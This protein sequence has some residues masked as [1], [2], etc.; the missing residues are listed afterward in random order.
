MK[1]AVTEERIPGKEHPQISPSQ[2]ARVTWELGSIRI[3]ALMVGWALSHFF[4]YTNSLILIAGLLFL[5]TR[6]LRPT[7]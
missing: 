6:K 7:D 4:P 5:Q 1:G 2:R 3:A